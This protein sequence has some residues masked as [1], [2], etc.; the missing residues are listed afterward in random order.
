M[1]KKIATLNYKLELLSD[2]FDSFLYK[3]ANIIL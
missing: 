2:K 3:I 1:S